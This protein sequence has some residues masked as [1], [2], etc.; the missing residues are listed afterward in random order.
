MPLPELKITSMKPSVERILA[1][2]CEKTSSASY[3]AAAHTSSNRCTSRG[4]D[5]D[6][7]VLGRPVD[8]GLMHEGER[9]AHQER[10]TR[11][12]QD[13]H[14]FTIERAR[15]RFDRG[16]GRRRAMARLRDR[17]AYTAPRLDGVAG[18]TA[19]GPRRR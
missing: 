17:L 6:V 14:R 1:S 8:P 4:P 7:E 5:E 2:Q 10:N 13:L 15:R 19:P 9:P 11:P 3:P 18:I 16:L 12:F